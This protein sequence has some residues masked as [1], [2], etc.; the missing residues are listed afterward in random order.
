MRTRSNRM[1]IGIIIFAVAL[2]VAAV[3][4]LGDDVVTLPGTDD[5]RSYHAL[6]LRVLG[7]HGFSFGTEWWPV[8][9][10]GEPTAHWSYLYTLYLALIYTVFGPH[11]LIA[12]LLQAVLVGVLH[13]YLAYR[14]GRHV[15]GTGVG[16]A[17]AAVTAVYAYFVYYAAALMTEAFYI[18][19]VLATL[20]VALRIS[21]SAN[22][23]ASEA[24]SQ[25]GDGVREWVLL[26]MC[27][28][29]TVL[30]RQV[31][32]LV[33][34]FI[35]LWL[36]WATRHTCHVSRVTFY[37][38]RFLCTLLIVL[39]LILP[40]TVRN[41]LAFGRFVLLNTNSGYAFFWANHPIYGTHFEPILPAE[42]G[43]YGSLI[44][45]ELRHLDEAALDQALLRRGVQ[46]V[47]D[48][49]VRY[50]QLSLSRIPAYF[51]F[52][53]SPVSSLTSNIA[54]VGS[55]GVCLPLMTYGLWL[56]AFGGRAR[57]CRREVLLLWSFIV[58]YSGIHLL[59]WSL[60]RYR[61][62][63]DAVLVVFAGLALVDLG[64]R[65]GIWPRARSWL[66]LWL[67]QTPEE[68]VTDYH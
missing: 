56:S 59:S 27:V 35:F 11:P 44:P 34:P 1:L 50:V 46:F 41:F 37:G 61:L 64:E 25:H 4:Y 51:E 14:I 20:A 29:V 24:V 32:L 36:W 16:L 68:A 5:Q 3:L 43:S 52:W 17:A 62:P 67:P 47:L 60:I 6:A 7:G 2:R 13:P 65:F 39:V 55:F 54:R 53:P 10:A 31:F 40:W 28:G 26:G 12:R 38:S 21:A 22:Q 30:L 49:P 66:G 19:A 33:V 18:T 42:M 9:Q 23:G 8:T 15:F 45:A 58:V 63:V 57:G 48:A